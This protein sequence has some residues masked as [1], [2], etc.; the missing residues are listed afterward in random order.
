MGADILTLDS[1]VYTTS[2]VTA[3]LAIGPLTTLAVDVDVTA[4]SGT[5]ASMSLF[6]E[7][8]G[9]DGHWYPIWSPTAI[10]AAGVTST[11]V[12]P[13]CATAAVVTSTIRFRW[14]V[15]GTTPSFTFSASIIG[16]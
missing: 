13:G 5:S 8:L 12:G 9:T 16:R 2:G 6:I 4:V 15:T 7:R 1:Q 14:A 10:T 3:P 11:S